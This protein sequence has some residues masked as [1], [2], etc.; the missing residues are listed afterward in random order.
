MI[1]SKRLFVGNLSYQT[2]AGALREAFGHFG[3]VTRVA[4]FAPSALGA[5]DFGIVEMAEGG[6]AAIAALNGSQFMG[7]TLTVNEPG[8]SRAAGHRV[9]KPQGRCPLT[10]AEDR[11][12]IARFE[13]EGGQ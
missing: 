10:P 5:R 3:T 6:G 11:A 13:D 2:T 1:V 4:V 8:A 9:E 12:D 7:R